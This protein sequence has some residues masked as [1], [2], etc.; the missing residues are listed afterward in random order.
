L[1]NTGKLLVNTGTV[2]VSGAVTQVSGTTLTAGTWRANG[3]AKSAAT[4][5]ITSA[6]NFTTIGSQAIVTLNGPNSTFTNLAALTA[7]QGSFSLQG[8]QSFTTAG[9]LTNSG[10][11]TLSPGSVLAVTGNFT[12]TSS[13]KLTLQMGGTNTHPRIGSLSATGTISLAGR[14]TATSTVTPAIGTVV[15]VVNNQG[16]SAITG[17]FANLPEGA[18]IKVKGM[19]F[20]ISYV[21]GSNRRSV[22]LKRTA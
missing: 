13:A 10:N 1:N 15:T 6:A 17:T 9:D 5:E 14:L 20:T 8:G 18:T 22:T 21:G 2:V 7:V 11:L 16:T 19:T 12:A 4:L 3:S